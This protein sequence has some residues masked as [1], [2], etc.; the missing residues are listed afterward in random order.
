MLN[1]IAEMNL[2]LLLLKP[3]DGDHPQANEGRRRG[4]VS[5]KL[6]LDLS[7]HLLVKEQSFKILLAKRF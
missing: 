7:C 1:P 4:L 5:N 6:N 2:C 3:A